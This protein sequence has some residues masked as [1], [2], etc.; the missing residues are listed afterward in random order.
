M[1]VRKQ[2]IIRLSAMESVTISNYDAAN[3]ID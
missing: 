2:V 1:L 3:A